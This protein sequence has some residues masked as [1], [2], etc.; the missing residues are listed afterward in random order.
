MTSESFLGGEPEE[1]KRTLDHI[2]D[3]AEQRHQQFSAARQQIDAVTMTAR[4]PDGTVQATV[5][6]SGALLDLVLTDRVTRMRPGE[7]S[8]QVLSC[9]QRAQTMIVDQVQAI[10]RDTVPADD[11]I[12]DEVVAGFSDRFPARPDQDAGHRTDA[13][14]HEMRLGSVD[15]DDWADQSFLR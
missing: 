1:I 9:V 7:I 6:S 4:S 2:V 3:E 5:R 12:A 10:L 11:A 13:R 14:P 8:A 15:D